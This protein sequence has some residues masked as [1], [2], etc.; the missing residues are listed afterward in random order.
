MGK[1]KKPKI[2]RSFRPYDD[3]KKSSTS[4]NSNSVSN[5]M[6]RDESEYPEQLLSPTRNISYQSD[7]H[8][9]DES[10]ICKAL[11]ILGNLV[12]INI[13]N[14]AIMKTLLKPD[15]FLLLRNKLANSTNRVLL[16]V[17]LVLK[18]ITSSDDN[19]VHS[20]II[21]ANIFDILL[22][23]FMD[24]N[25]FSSIEG[26]DRLEGISFCIC[27][28]A[29]HSDSNL[30]RILDIP[31]FLET[32]YSILF[33]TNM[34]LT[35]K[36]VVS[37]LI[38]IITDFNELACSKLASTNS[39]DKLFELASG[40]DQLSRDSNING[41]IF[42]YRLF[43]LRCCGIIVNIYCSLFENVE[44]SK[45]CRIQEVLSILFHYLEPDISNV[46]SVVDLLKASD[47]QFLHETDND[48]LEDEEIQQN[49]QQPKTNLRSAVVQI[50]SLDVTKV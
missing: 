27:N 24:K 10:T 42:E 29:S 45:L 33:Q 14:S 5:D 22:T 21:E 37:N 17:I 20:R 36:L 35:L 25:N 43:Y 12:A 6:M 23:K 44:I 41:N 1:A 31:N 48:I 26:L 13:T 47:V 4:F 40:S 3:I 18:N 16:E 19:D 38:L 8:S 46:N 39:I 11:R 32:V 15:V 28:M 7:L 30:N 34:R 49:F 50:N 9:T 2:R